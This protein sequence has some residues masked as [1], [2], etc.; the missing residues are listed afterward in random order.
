[1]KKMIYSSKAKREL[2]G[3]GK[4]LGYNYYILNLGTHPTAYINTT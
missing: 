2:L 1:M 3:K 4:Y